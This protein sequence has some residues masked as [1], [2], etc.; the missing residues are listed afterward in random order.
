MLSGSV[1]NRNTQ[2]MKLNFAILLL[3]FAFVGCRQDVDEFEPYVQ[4]AISFPEVVSLKSIYR[5]FQADENSEIDLGKGELLIVPANSMVDDSG[6]TL[7]GKIDLNITQIKKKSDLIYAYMNSNIGQHNDGQVDNYHVVY[8]KAYHESHEVFVKSGQKIRLK[9]PATSL[10]G[11]SVW[12]GRAFTP[13]S[14][15]WEVSGVGTLTSADWSVGGEQFSGVSY[16][17]GQMGWISGAKAFPVDGYSLCVNLEEGLDVKKTKAY[18]IFEDAFTVTEL[19]L[20]SDTGSFCATVPAGTKGH[21][22]VIN[23][24]EKGVYRYQK[25]TLTIEEDTNISARP[26]ITVLENIILA[27]NAL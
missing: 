23:E 26:Q 13:N 20:Y 1:L 4:T 27:L 8:I 24:E 16:D 18:F 22:V 7:T 17:V 3:L 10:G 2:P 9:S 6:V 21:L 12:V 14:F 19:K 25:K 15:G 11:G 5:S